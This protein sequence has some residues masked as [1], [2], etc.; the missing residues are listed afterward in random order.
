MDYLKNVEKTLTRRNFLMSTGMLTLGSFLPP[1]FLWADSL[2]EDDLIKACGPAS[3]YRSKLSVAFV[4]RE[5]EYGMWWPGQIYD[6]DAALKKYQSQISETAQLL[7]MDLDLR[8]SPIF[9]NEEADHWIGQ[10]KD[11]QPDGV[12]VV[13]LD[14]Q[15]HAW[16]TV[17]KAIDTKIPTIVFSPL[18]TSFTTNTTKPS[19]KEGVYICSTDDFRQVAGAIKMINAG[20]K[21]RET[22]FL[23]IKGDQRTESKIAHIG[24]KLQYIP[25]QDFVDAYKSIKNN[26]TLKNLTADLIRN[27]TMLNGPSEQDV[28]NGIKSYLVAKNLLEREGCD[29]ITMDCLGALKDSKISLP[30]IA[31]SKMNDHQIPAACEADL[32]A[33]VTHAIVQYMFDK[34]GFQQDPVAETV[35]DCLI[36]SHC[37][38]PTK[39]NGFKNSSEP[40]D[41]VVH[42]ANRDATARTV[43]QLGQRITVADLILSEKKEEIE[44]IIS[45]G[46]VVA[47]KSIPPA[48]GCVVAPMVKLDN[49]NDTL[50][51]PG[52]HQVFFYGDHKKDLKAYCGLYGIKPVVV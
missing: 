11:R 52:F 17:G 20:A 44:M 39:L 33:C 4:R 21:L 16:P 47:N 34:P 42:H 12:M 43:W 31:W 40:Y 18:G 13:V 48:G 25:A 14:R 5:G 35:Q 3:K 27:A 49:V 10:T 7:N 38:C 9:S 26:N 24:T 46:E 28:S 8:P 19:K 32:G 1:Q 29:G 15:Q 41:I 22:K 23:V 30:C 6:G 36:G 51:Y 45:A 50:D 2:L 37:S